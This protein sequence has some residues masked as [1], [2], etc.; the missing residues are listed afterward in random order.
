GRADRLACHRSTLASSTAGTGTDPSTKI[1]RIESPANGPRAR[2]QRRSGYSRDY[3]HR[4][5]FSGPSGKL[6]PWRAT[7]W[8]QCAML[9]G[10]VQRR[11]LREYVISAQ[12]KRT[13]HLGE[14]WFLE[15]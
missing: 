9:L 1:F 5:A 2:V 11:H 3:L 10:L 15:R 12:T 7:V 8:D 6:T 14:N 4:S 13:R